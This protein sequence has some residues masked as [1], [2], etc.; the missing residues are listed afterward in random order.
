[1]F[2]KCYGTYMLLHHQCCIFL[3]SSGLKSID[4][5]LDVCRKVLL[6]YT[7]KSLMYIENSCYKNGP[8]LSLMYIENTFLN[9]HDFECSIRCKNST[10]IGKKDFSTYI[11]Y[12][13]V[14][15]IHQGLFDIHQRNFCV[16]GK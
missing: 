15:D 12:K 7:E 10:I 16:L 8:V 11:I 2:S 6:M 5:K 3:Y 1:M 9:I 13:A 4:D 14:F